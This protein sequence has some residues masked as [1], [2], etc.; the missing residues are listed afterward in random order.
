MISKI[1]HGPLTRPKERP[2]EDAAYHD[3]V[4][5][6]FDLDKEPGPDRDDP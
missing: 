1:L 6:L 5:A 2:D 3:T 4:R